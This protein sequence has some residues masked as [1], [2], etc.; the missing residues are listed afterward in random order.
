MESARC[1]AFMYAADTGSFTKAAERLNYTPSGVS[2]LVGALENE[3]GLTLLR[4]TRKGVTLTSDGEILLPAV[5]EFLEKENRIYELA[6]EVKGLL[7]GSVTIAAYSSISTHWLPEV[8]R[9]FEQD[10]P[11]IEIRLMEGIRQEVTRWLDEKKADIGFL[12][13]QEPMPYEW[14]PLD[15]DEMLA[16]LPKDHLYASKE[17]Y[18]LINCETDSFIM[19]ALGRDDDVVSL[20]ERNGIKLNIHFTTLENFATM[21]MIEKGLGMSVMNNLITEKWNCDVVKI[22]VDPP[23][24][25]TLGLAVPSYKQASP[26]VKRFIKYAVERL[27]KIE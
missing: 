27:K 1:K 15:Y 14:T 5:R 11:Q 25:I 19:P 8:I 24:R 6:A 18:P 26:A 20:F 10:Y 4:R 12:S 22:P 2:Q 13:Y 9:D 17:S 23:S 7:V 3:T 21:A 16:V